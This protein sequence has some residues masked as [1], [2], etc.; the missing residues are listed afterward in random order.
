MQNCIRPHRNV[1]FV[2]GLLIEHDIVMLINFKL[3]SDLLLYFVIII[4]TQIVSFGTC[5]LVHMQWPTYQ[6]FK[7]NDLCTQNLGS[8]P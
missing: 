3:L 6:V 1:K 8:E 5:H 7:D 4:P 2:K